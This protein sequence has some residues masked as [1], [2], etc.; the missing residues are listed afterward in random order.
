MSSSVG[1]PAGAIHFRL[2]RPR[3]AGLYQEAAPM[4]AQ[5]G[6]IISRW[7][8]AAGRLRT[9]AYGPAPGWET[10]T[11]A[12][13]TAGST[14]NNSGSRDGTHKQRDVLEANKQSRH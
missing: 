4:G 10:I 9:S 8:A 6:V 11:F 14:G 7:P 5:I 2:G 13:R 1:L 12:P 3:T